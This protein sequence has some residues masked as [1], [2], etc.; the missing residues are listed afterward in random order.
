MSQAPDAAA[1]GA[2]ERHPRYGEANLVWVDMEMSG[3]NPDCDRVLEVAAV[4]TDAQLEVIAEGPVLVVRQSDAVLAGMDSW[5]TATHGRSGLTEKVRASRLAE[6]EAEDAEWQAGQQKLAQA[7]TSVTP[8]QPAEEAEMSHPVID[9]TIEK[10]KQA[11]AEAFE[12]GREELRSKVDEAIERAK[13]GDFRTKV[14]EPPAA[15]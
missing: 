4:V 12:K 14:T 2:A 13:N 6:Q 1:P 9:Q 10:G 3:L 5:N 11:I 7:R 8:I 15:V